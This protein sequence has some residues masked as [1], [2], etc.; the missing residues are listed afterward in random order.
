MEYDSDASTITCVFLNTGSQNGNHM[1]SI[2]YGSCQQEFSHDSQ[3]STTVEFPDRVVIQIKLSG[4][5]CYVYSV[6]AS[7]GTFS[8]IVEGNINTG[9]GGK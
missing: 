3:G 7:N 1:C 8:V 9:S 6:K 4:S 5:E 2:R